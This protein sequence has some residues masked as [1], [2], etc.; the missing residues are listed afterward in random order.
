[1]CWPPAEQAHAAILGS[2]LPGPATDFSQLDAALAVAASAVRRA[3]G[4]DLSS[5]R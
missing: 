4:Q 5:F 1:M 2:L 3:R